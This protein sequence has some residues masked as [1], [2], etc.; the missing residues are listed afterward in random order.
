[1]R[2]VVQRVEEASV[3]VHG[4][5][6][7]SIA[8]GLLVFLGV[9]EGDTASDRDWMVRKLPA[10]RIFADDAGKMSRS[11][12]DI[13]GSVL[14]VSQFTLAADVRKGARP[15][16]HRAM[17]AALAALEVERVQQALALAVPVATGRF[18]ADM[19][20]RLLNDGPVTLWLDSRDEDRAAPGED[21]RDS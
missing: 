4:R 2:A 13:A 5:I 17:P 18:A 21:S 9:M 10:L 11:V 12:V 7:G 8:R 6:V 3:E 16:F 1:M 14:V 20:V 15:S 19:R